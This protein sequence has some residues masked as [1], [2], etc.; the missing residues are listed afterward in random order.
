MKIWNTAICEANGIS[1]HFTRTNG[2]GTHVVML[3]GLMTNGA[4]FTPVVR[5]LADEFDVIMPD[6]RGHGSSS[7]PDFGYGYED[8]ASDVIGLIKELKLN[9]PILIGHSMGGMTAALM[10]SRHSKLLGGVILAD[11]SFL[12]P[13]LQREVRDSDVAEQHRRI[14]KRSFDE[15]V[16]DA[17]T[18]SPHRSLAMLEL[19]A[20]ARL[21]TSMAAFD[22]LTP[23]NPDFVQIVREI[24]VPTLLV[25]G[26][27]GVVSS[28]MAKELQIVNPRLQVELI[29]KSGHGLPFDQPERFAHVIKSFLMAQQRKI[30]ELS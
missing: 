7:V 24:H 23:P 3:H 16:C 26:D 28:E 27:G 5:L 13:K 6:A 21:E 8:H 25:I 17:R 30:S 20:Q 14:L 29:E 2:N 11:P 1:I 12:S 9:L 18:K 4:C 15:L 22:L 10:A 19:L